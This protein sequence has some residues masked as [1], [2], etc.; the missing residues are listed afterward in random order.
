EKSPFNSHSELMLIN[1]INLEN[2]QVGDYFKINDKNN[3]DICKEILEAIKKSELSNINFINM[4]D[5]ANVRVYY[6]NAIEIKLG[7]VANLDYK[8]KFAKEIINTKLSKDDQGVLDV[9]ING[10]SFFRQC[11]VK[12]EGK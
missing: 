10:K 12:I 1:G 6:N 9:Q 11:E 8:F 2:I 3:Y 7:N 4:S 5:L